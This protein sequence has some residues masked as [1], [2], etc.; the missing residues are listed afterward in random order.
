MK[1]KRKQG[2]KQ[3]SS[4]ELYTDVCCIGCQITHELYET[5]VIQ[6]SEIILGLINSTIKKLKSI[7]IYNTG[8]AIF[9]GNGKIFL[10]VLKN[11]LICLYFVFGSI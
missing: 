3:L 7:K 1:T 8:F 9:K 11:M 6:T 10:L 5:A 2:K 4:T